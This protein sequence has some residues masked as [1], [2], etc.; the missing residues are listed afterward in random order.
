MIWV[1]RAVTWGQT[2][3]T[4]CADTPCTQAGVDRLPYSQ[5]IETFVSFNSTS[6]LQNIEKVLPKSCISL[7]FAWIQKKSENEVALF[8][9]IIFGQILTFS[10]LKPN[11]QKK[12]ILGKF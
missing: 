1:N 12:D 3:C 8:L 7:S 4:D 5:L 10:N 9:F 6:V 11:L 2:G